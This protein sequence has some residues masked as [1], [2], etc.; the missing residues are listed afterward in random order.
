M[1]REYFILTYDSSGDATLTLR[2]PGLPSSIVVSEQTSPPPPPPRHEAETNY[3]IGFNET[4]F[5]LRLALFWVLITAVINLA[6]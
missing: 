4:A 2:N 5:T 6:Q 3:L 1:K